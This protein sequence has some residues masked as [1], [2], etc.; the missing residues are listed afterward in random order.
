[1]QK[2]RWGIMS[3]GYIADLFVEGLSF[4]EDAEAV[5][6]GSRQQASADRFADKWHIP[7][8]HGSYEPLVNDPDV[9]VVYIGTPHPFHYENTLLCLNAGKH[10][11]VEKPFSMNARQAETMITLAREKGLFL[12]EAMWTRYLPAMVLARKWLADGAIGDV[13]LVR[14][15]FSFKGEF[16]PTHRLLNPD[17]GGGALLDAGVY[18]ISLAS[19]VLGSPQTISSTA[20][21]GETGVDVW[22]SYMFGYEN[23]KTAL[24]SS[25]V[26]LSVP[27][28]AEF[29]GTKGY[30][31]IHQP[32][33]NPRV[34]TLDQAA[35]N[36][37]AKLIV[38][39]N[40]YDTQTLHVP[41]VGNGYN[42]EAMEV[43]EC[44]R[45]GLLE[46][47]IMPLDETLD[48]M[49]TMDTIRGQWGLTYSVE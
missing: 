36:V 8:R 41:T 10:V 40:V 30:I 11:L 45:A 39:G 23:G 43:G 6:V 2:T 35:T 1:M 3:T 44:L 5:A 31:K 29:I 7:H 28:E 32:W 27:V 38:D 49:R 22:S 34:V 19:M 14:A 13:A 21:F 17:L 48:I 33:L 12:M 16:G 42:Y 26:Q 15:T 20:C 47:S 4:V 9:D 46:S 18:P 25:G 24:L 37:G